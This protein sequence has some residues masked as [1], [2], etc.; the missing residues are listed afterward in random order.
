MQQYDWRM[1][2]W[3]RMNV[4]YDEMIYWM[5]NLIKSTIYVCFVCVTN[6]KP[7]KCHFLVFI[8]FHFEHL[9]IQMSFFLFCLPF[10][11]SYNNK[12]NTFIALNR[13]I[14]SYICWCRIIWCTSTLFIKICKTTFQH[15]FCYA[16]SCHFICHGLY[17]ITYDA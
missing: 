1:N 13:H 7:S 17:D 2:E 10:L 5:K 3:C 4:K 12:F 14:C 15:H 9:M 16:F 6:H 8:Q 11:R